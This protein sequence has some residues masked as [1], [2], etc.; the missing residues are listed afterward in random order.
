MERH[1]RP[2]ARRRA[3]WATTCL[4]AA[5]LALLSVA[6]LA[7]P[8]A[9][10]RAGQPPGP[11]ALAHRSLKAALEH[12]GLPLRSQVP[13]WATRPGHHP[14]FTPTPRQ[15]HAAAHA[16]EE[17]EGA[18]TPTG[19]GEGPGGEAGT[20]PGPGNELGLR[21]GSGYCPVPPLRYL[22]GVVQHEPKVH[23]VFWG[24]NW[25]SAGNT[26]AKAKILELL[27][28][29]S[30]SAYQSILTQYFDA[31]G[32][33]SPNVSVNSFVD[34]RVAAPSKVTFSSMEPEIG[35]AIEQK[36]WKREADA[37]FVLLSAPGTTYEAGF[38]EFCAYHD[39]DGQ[40]GI[41]DFVPWAGDAPFGTTSNCAGYYGKGDATK[42]T[43][44]MASHEYS[45]SATDPRW[46]TAPGWQ[47]LEGYELADMCSTPYD[48][49][50]GKGSAKVYVQGLYDDRQNACS[51]EDKA[52]P[53]VLALTDSPSEVTRHTARIN[54]TVNPE[55]SATTYRFEYG[56]TAS[57]GTSV[58]AEAQSVGSGS[59]NVAVHADL[60]GLQTEQLYHYRVLA[61]NS[62]GTTYGE[63]RT[64]LPSV[65]TIRPQGEPTRTGASWLNDVDCPT[66][67][68]CVAVGHYYNAKNLALAYVGS[69][70]SWAWK[71]LP[72]PKEGKLT[73]LEGVSCSSATA[74][75]AVGRGEASGKVVPT[76]ARW[77]GS[78]W[79]LQEV[80]VPAGTTYGALYSVSCPSGGECVAVG[81]YKNPEGVFVD[82]SARW[83]GG[84]W[85]TLLTPNPSAGYSESL[86]EDVSCPQA[87]LCKAVG[88]YNPS[89]GGAA[90][91]VIMAW[92][93]S[94]WSIQSAAKSEGYLKGISCTSGEFCLAVGGYGTVVERWNGS[95]WSSVTTPTLSEADGGYLSAVSCPTATQ[96]TTVGGAFS[97]I[98]G[99]SYTLAEDW[100]GS[101]WA[102]S[103]TPR[104]S[105]QAYNELTGVSCRAASRC[106][107]VGDSLA[108][109]DWEPLIETRP[110][111]PAYEASFGSKGSGNGQFESPWGMDVNVKGNAWVADRYNNRIE[112]FNEKGEYLSQIGST[113]SGKGQLVEP[114]DVA[115]SA[116]GNLWVTDGGNN[117]IEEFT[118]QGGFIEML[119]GEVNKTKT[120]EAGSTE[121]ERNLCPVDPADVCQKG[122]QGD[123]Q[124]RLYEP[125]GIDEAADGNLWVANSRYSAIKEITPA[126]VTLRSVGKHGAGNAEFYGPRGLEIDGAGDVW[127]ADSQNN[128]V[129]E[130]SSTGA[131]LR[132]FGGKGSGD[133]QF[134]EPQAIAVTPSGSLLVAD[135]FN[136]RVEQFELNGEF[137][138][139]LG[140]EGSGTA[141]LKEPRG[142]AA[143][144]GGSIYISDTWNN[145]VQRWYEPAPPTAISEPPT[146]IGATSARL[147]ADINPAGLATAYHFEY[148]TT[149]YA[150]GEAPHGTPVP[151][152]DVAIGAGKSHVEVSQE[153]KGLQ[154]H[155]TYHYRV[156]ASNSEGT[157]Y[158]E[159]KTL[160]TIRASGPAL[161]PPGGAF[162]ASFSPAGEQTVRLRGGSYPINCATEAGVKALGGEGQL[163]SAT[164]GTATLVL[165]NCKTIFGISCTTSG[166]AEGTI[167]AESLPFRLVYLSD[168]KPG[169]LFEP[170]AKSGALATASCPFIGPIKLSGSGV[171]GR[172]TQPALGESSSTLTVNLNAPET[173]KEKYAQ[174]Y[175]KTEAGAEYGLTVSV[176]GGKAEAA[177]LE[178][179]P[180]ASFSGGK[181]ELREG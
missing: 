139:Q 30:G 3:F 113:G 28:V 103:A 134:S 156:V 52:P 147:A 75:T 106:S 8:P 77:N 9:L 47:D 164:A 86:L 167:K 129:Q 58:P 92:N 115:V 153:L 43:S 128:R 84:A 100:N 78:E 24:S 166:Q 148:D 80:P 15:L 101:S 130:L 174:E 63:D 62:S 42:A 96:C 51:L 31:S 53:H 68:A 97:K 20:K 141:Q 169:V 131:Y 155:T 64:F 88:W 50:P 176:N 107:A 170:N 27:E 36:G 66:R 108:G 165:H 151:A 46:D 142:L 59:E 81:T 122:T 145:R 160:S 44:L 124:G 76:A 79:S 159:D 109:G 98:D 137:E 181:A 29:L 163:E 19:P 69:A 158:G 33:I 95:S 105:E 117:R 91:K 73:N 146:E 87:A 121:A 21:C 82:Y 104:E 23:V 175:V 71:A 173:G 13:A 16:H 93:G 90:Q 143:G 112:E 17:G 4:R 55:G 74:C 41:Y 60:S 38:G 54:A 7:G 70:S 168:G 57:Y 45:E 40:G 111:A 48:E 22:G 5:L 85:S 102:L 67:E 25:N 35:Y 72:T 125:W 39:V 149:K 140:T 152:S 65:W 37:Q 6:A 34:T 172:I 12:H 26:A 14:Y 1:W 126:G 18:E 161:Q 144:P 179:E 178:A 99:L 138:T 120:E 49:I 135:R 123:T 2:K 162:P 136:G 32:R 150:N 171:L 56:T 89:G 180:V 110:L 61:T 11:R 154:A 127:V 177:E 157:V 118:P 116:A 133:G 10:A 94:A 83:S 132:Q 119:G 114:L